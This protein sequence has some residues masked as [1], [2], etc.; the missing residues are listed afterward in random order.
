MVRFGK[1]NEF[2]PSILLRSGRT[3][4]NRSTMVRFG[5]RSTLKRE[6]PMVQ[7]AKREP[8]DRI[9]MVRITSQPVLN[10]FSQ[11]KKAIVRRYNGDRTEQNKVLSSCCCCSCFCLFI[12]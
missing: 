1:R 5:K 4:I 9:R 12:K 2:K 11:F 3:P 8:M 6:S 7:S 10:E